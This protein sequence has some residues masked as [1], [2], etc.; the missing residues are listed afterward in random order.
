MGHDTVCVAGA[1]GPSH[2]LSDNQT[3]TETQIED[4]Y[5]DTGPGAE[6]SLGQK[7]KLILELSQIISCSLTTMAGLKTVKT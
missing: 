4:F 5:T 3:P 6:P 7:L 1:G 2:F